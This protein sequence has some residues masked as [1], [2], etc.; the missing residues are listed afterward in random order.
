LE[1]E[2]I[3]SK[4]R[5][6]RHGRR[7]GGVAF[8][9][10]ALYELLQN[11]LY[12]GEIAHKGAVYPGQH[13]AIVDRDTWNRVQSQLQGNLKAPRR[14]P[15]MSKQGLLTGLIFDIAGHRFVPTHTA[16][17]DKRYRYYTSQAVINGKRTRASGPT[18]LPAEELEE[19][20]IAEVLMFLQ[21][22][23]RIQEVLNPSDADGHSIKHAAE[24]AAKWSSVQKNQVKMLVPRLVKR[25]IVDNGSIE[26]QLS[27][28]AI[29]EAATG[30]AVSSA[31]L[32][33]SLSEMIKLNVRAKFRRCGGEL[34]LLLPSE[35][36]QDTPATPSLAR[37]V[38]RARDW[39]EGIIRGEFSNQRAIAAE[40]GLD[41]RYISKIIPLAFLAPDI[42]ETLLDGKQ[43]PDLALN[44]LVSSCSC[45][46]HI[47]R[48]AIS[49]IPGGF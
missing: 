14:R 17:G 28:E 20:V 6:S 36:A 9:R 31:K 48:M 8:S 15:G 5:V 11:R 18:R 47:Q 46:W 34:R 22:H 2:K 27:R 12:L 40:T 32:A 21:S 1:A 49:A 43:D 30:T 16:K 13:A 19:L 4:V 38:A 29:W 41:E 44:D 42:T 26:L 23:Q 24:V 25:I 7:S 45:D 33:D 10:G 35:A 39:V 3:H 37:A